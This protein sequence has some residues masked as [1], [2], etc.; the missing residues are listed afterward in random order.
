MF[1]VLSEIM[2][3][4][5]IVNCIWKNHEN[6]MPGSAQELQEPQEAPKFLPKFEYRYR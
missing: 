3:L 4:W 2:K 1:A 6:N 5:K